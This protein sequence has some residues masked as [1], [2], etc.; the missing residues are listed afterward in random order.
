MFYLWK[1]WY[2]VCVSTEVCVNWY[3]VCVSTEACMCQLIFCR[4]FGWVS[5]YILSVWCLCKHMF[6][7]CLC[8]VHVSADAQSMSVSMF[9]LGQY[10]HVVCQYIHFVYVYVLHVSVFMFNLCLRVVYV[11]VCPCQYLRFCLFAV[12]SKYVSYCRGS[13]LSQW[14]RRT[15]A[16]SV[17]WRPDVWH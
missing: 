5:T 2:F 1:Y 4:C 11:S 13:P 3:F 15:A 7:L 8:F 12:C 10:L 16:S 17:L 9:C 6:C 14:C